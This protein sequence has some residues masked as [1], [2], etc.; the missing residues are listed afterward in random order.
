MF[1]AAAA[2]VTGGAVIG[3]APVWATYKAAVLERTVARLR[4]EGNARFP[5]LYV[6]ALPGYR[7]GVVLIVPAADKPEGYTLDYGVF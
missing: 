4:D 7:I 3:A 5:S 1:V 6:F 2:F